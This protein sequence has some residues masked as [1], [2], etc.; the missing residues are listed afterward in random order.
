MVSGGK[1]IC[2]STPSS[3][4]PGFRNPTKQKPKQ[5]IKFAQE[6]VFK[7]D[8][9]AYLTSE[10]RESSAGRVKSLRTATLAIGWDVVGGCDR[11]MIS[12][13]EWTPSSGAS[14]GGSGGGCGCR[15][16]TEPGNELSTI[17]G[18]LE[19]SSAEGGRQLSTIRNRSI[20]PTS[21]PPPPL[22]GGCWFLSSSSSTCSTGAAASYSS[23]LRQFTIYHSDVTQ[24]SLFSHF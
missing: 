11:I 7:N 3:R 10:E 12:G 17:F 8:T 20:R 18:D 2:T 22:D 5:K 13:S 16:I 19:V 23:A 21:V 15:T 6:F 9:G 4:F 1:V 14:G 24:L